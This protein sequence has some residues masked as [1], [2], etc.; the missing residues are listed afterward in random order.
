MGIVR[1]KGD[2]NRLDLM[3]SEILESLDDKHFIYEV[4]I[5]EAVIALCFC[6]KVLPRILL[7]VF[8]I[9]IELLPQAL[10]FCS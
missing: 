9:F 10:R 5:K 2:K 1:I 7:I 8:K 4:H 6:L 3:Q